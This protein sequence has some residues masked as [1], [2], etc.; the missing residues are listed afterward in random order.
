MRI[1]Q[2]SDLSR[3]C[4]AIFLLAISTSVIAQM[5]CNYNYELFFDSETDRSLAKGCAE[6]YYCSEEEALKL[7]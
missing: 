5:K 6:N 1:F 3:R 7:P 2:L 4:I